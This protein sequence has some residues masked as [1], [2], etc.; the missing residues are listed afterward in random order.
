MKSSAV[1]IWGAVLGLGAAAQAQSYPTQAVRLVVPFS[2][3]GVT[4]SLARILADKLERVWKQSV[5]VENRPGLPGTAGVAQSAPDGYTLMMTSNGHVIARSLSK[6]VSFDPV[7]DFAGII[8][9]ADLPFAMIAPL[10]LP[11]KTLKEFIDL[12]KAQPGKFNFASSGIASSAFLMAETFRQ[13]ADLKLVHVPFKGAPDALTAVM[14]N[15]VAFYFGPVPEAAELSSAGKV[16]VIAISSPTR[17]TQLPDVP[18][19]QEAGVP[20][21][22]YSSWFGILAPARTPKEVIAKVHQDVAALLKQPD[23]I[24]RLANLG[25]L[26]LP[27]TPDEFSAL[28][29]ADA[30]RYSG[31]LKAAGIEAK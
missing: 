16:R 9:V 26:P 4:D 12:A 14:R 5:F 7:A 6:N 19:I 27:N 2:S 8:R 3:G 24:Q 28:I 18:S 20:S 15:D 23:V 22:K 1:L 10:E 29:K 30:E 11:A 13:A 21:F 31:V 25:S 17:S